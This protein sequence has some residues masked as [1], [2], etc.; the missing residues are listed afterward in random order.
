MRVREALPTHLPA[1]VAL[2]EDVL[3]RAR[4]RGAARLE[5]TSNARRERTRRFYEDLG[6]AASHV[7]FTYYL[8]GQG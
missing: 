1:I 2:I 3:A 8:G 5:L 4:S 7:G 6:F